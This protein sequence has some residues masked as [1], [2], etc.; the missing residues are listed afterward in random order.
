MFSIE[1]KSEELDNQSNRGIFSS[2]FLILS[3]LFVS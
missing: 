1:D 3:S 2:C